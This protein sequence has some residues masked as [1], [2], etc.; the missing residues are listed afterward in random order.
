MKL[1]GRKIFLFAGFMMMVGC[2]TTEGVVIPESLLPIKQTRIMLVN[3]LGEARV[4]SENGR[5]FSSQFHDRS[6]K[7]ID[8]TAKTT[9]RLYTKVFILGARRPYDIAVE[10]HIEHRDPDSHEFH[11]IG[12]D[13]KLSMTQAKVIRDALN[14][15]LGKTQN[16]DEGS[17]F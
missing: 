16:I 17:P 2:Q 12:L 9:E 15:S 4:I 3:T 8:I 5:E 11:D 14:L 7:N 6:L 10:V 13:E 1:S